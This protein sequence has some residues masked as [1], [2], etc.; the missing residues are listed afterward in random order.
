MT[1]GE[2]TTEHGAR[3]LNGIME[4]NR[5]FQKK[6]PVVLYTELCSYPK[7]ISDVEPLLY[8]WYNLFEKVEFDM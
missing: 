7:H 6:L 2:R 8:P 5:Q 3:I 4:N 1:N